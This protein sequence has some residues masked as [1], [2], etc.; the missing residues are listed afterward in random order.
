MIPT[1]LRPAGR[2]QSETVGVVLLTGVVVVLAAVTGAVVIG[3]PA[4]ETTPAVN[5]QVSATTQQ[6]TV[7]H[8][9]GDALATSDV[10][11]VIEG[12]SRQR[13]GLDSYTQLQGSDSTRF[14]PGDI[15][16][17]AN[18]VSGEQI[19]VTAVHVPSNTVLDTATA[20]V[21]VTI[22]ARIDYTPENP[23]PTD[24]IEF[25]GSRS[26]V[27][28]STITAWEWEFNGTTKNGETVTYDAP[29]DGEYPVT[30]TVTA[31]DGRTASN[32][33]TVT[34]YNGFPT[35]SFTYSPTNPDPG[36]DIELDASGS[37]DSDGSIA[38]YEWEFNDSGNVDA[39]GQTATTNFS[40]AGNYSV[41]LTVT[42]EDGAT[43]RES[44]TVR[45]QNES[46]PS[47]TITGTTITSI[48]GSGNDQY[49]VTVTFE[50]TD[51]DGDIA[52]YTATLY[53]SSN[54]VTQL[55]QRPDGSYDGSSTTVTLQDAQ[56]N[57][58]SNPYYVVVR[59]GDDTNR[60]GEA[61]Q[62]VDA[63]NGA[64]S[65]DFDYEPT[66]PSAGQS[67]DFDASA[68]SDPDG[69]SL[70]YEWDWTSDGTYDDTGRLA[71]HTYSSDGTY[72]VTLR[73]SDG[74]GGSGTE[75]QTVVVG[76]GGTSPLV[77]VIESVQDNSVDCQRNAGNNQC[78][79]QSSPTVEFAVDW[80]ATDDG[81]D[82]QSVTVELVAPDGTTV[83]DSETTYSGVGS[84]SG[85]T[86]LTDD[87]GQWN[88][89]YT[90]RV[91]ASNSTAS[92]TD[93]RTEV[94]DGS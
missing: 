23:T 75:T 62:T 79:G 91:T 24:T 32:T 77:A 82:L 11:L 70:T 74:Q 17:G 49:D 21:E 26:T 50:A 16:D 93:T 30:L 53:D 15:W 40:T 88:E 83:A 34:V 87:P 36:E 1:R 10:D 22:A 68:S 46:P 9:G 20:D 3:Q 51:P 13:V 57:P 33:Q 66:N 73:V 19:R 2:A 85:Q 78:T 67:V 28:D 35:A 39:T 90:V 80:S 48:D 84:A 43:N 52:N 44:R 31:D 4:S 27:K 59:V 86:T 72:D 7:D 94:A 41:R 63:T 8:V 58:G 14:A 60:V 71:T 92:D 42:D 18:P 76:S 38:S 6:I 5:V 29:D 89:E 61:T 45:V 81:S 12:D 47:V 56:T 65:A 25:N 69:D 64:P 37:S 54:R 55:D